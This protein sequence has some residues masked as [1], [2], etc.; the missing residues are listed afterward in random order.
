MTYVTTFLFS[1]FLLCS[2]NSSLPIIRPHLC[3]H[4]NVFEK[5]LFWKNWNS[6][7]LFLICYSA[8]I[9]NDPRVWQLLRAVNAKRIVVFTEYFFLKTRVRKESLM[10]PL[11]NRNRYAQST[12]QLKSLNAHPYRPGTLGVFFLS[13]LAHSDLSLCPVRIVIR[14]SLCASLFAD[15]DG[16]ISG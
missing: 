16:E 15:T 3:C 4:R 13:L 2:L 14:C 7:H 12:S 1:I 5:S 6:L 11:R 10:E 9:W 8:E